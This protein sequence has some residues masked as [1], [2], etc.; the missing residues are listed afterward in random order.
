[1]I[2][3]AQAM[4]DAMAEFAQASDE[5]AKT[6]TRL[7]EARREETNGLNRVNEAQKQIDAVLKSVRDK[8]PAE[9]DWKRVERAKHFVGQ[10][11]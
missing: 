10:E 9:S 11:A 3:D 7:A 5:L 8:A 6:R 4:N 2:D 1:M